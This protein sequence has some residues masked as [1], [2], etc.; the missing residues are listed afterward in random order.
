M[1]VST[2]NCGD[3]RLCCKVLG[4]VELKKPVGKWCSHTCKA[5]CGIYETRPQSC[6]DYECVW[7]SVA[8]HTEHPLPMEFRPDK[9]HIVFTQSSDDEKQLSGHVDP[10]RPDAHKS[11]AAIDFMTL[12]CQQGYKIILSVPNDKTHKTLVRADPFGKMIV[13]RHLITSTDPVTGEE[14][15]Q[16]HD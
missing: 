7:L 3:C 16:V 13:T 1:T 15:I 14:F 11:K 2:N 8:V 10:G 4:I 9:L 12:V 5:G 6:Q